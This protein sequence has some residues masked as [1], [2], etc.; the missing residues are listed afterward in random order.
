MPLL[1]F[2]TPSSSHTI[3]FA[4]VTSTMIGYSARELLLIMIL[5]KP[6]GTL[7]EELDQAGVRFHEPFPGP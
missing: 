5:G 6:E 7:I 3:A 1:A 4:A 2:L